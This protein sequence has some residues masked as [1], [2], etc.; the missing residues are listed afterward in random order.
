MTTPSDR[1]ALVPMASVLRV[2]PDLREVR[3]RMTPTYPMVSSMNTISPA[4]DGPPVDL[5][6]TPPQLWR[7]LQPWAVQKMD[8]YAG[9]AG[10]RLANASTMASAGRKASTAAQQKTRRN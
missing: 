6:G 2:T 10:V 4:Q 9:R 3:N 8:P 1:P 5:P 7:L